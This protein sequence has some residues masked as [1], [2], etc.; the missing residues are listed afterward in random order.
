MA[1]AEDLRSKDKCLYTLKRRNNYTT[2]ILF[3]EE[4][5]AAKR[6]KNADKRRMEMVNVT[7]VR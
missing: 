5:F 6:Y 3:M 1:V 4:F 7:S 2:D